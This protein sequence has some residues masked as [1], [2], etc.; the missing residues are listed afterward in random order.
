MAHPVAR[1]KF[2]NC[3]NYSEKIV[4]YVYDRDQAL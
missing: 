3:T 2:C 4:I 1:P